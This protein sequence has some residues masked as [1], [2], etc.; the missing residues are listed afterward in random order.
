MAEK[1]KNDN[2]SKLIGLMA[3]FD[4][5]NS[6]VAACNEAREAG[7]KK[8]D[9]YSPFPVHGIDPAIGIKRT[10]LPLIVLGAAISAVFIGLGLQIYTNSM[11]QAWPFPGYAFKISGKPLLSIPANIPVTF[12]IIVLT[13]AITTFLGMWILNKLPR[14]SNPLHRI[15]RF[16]RV[17]NDKFFLVLEAHDEK[18]NRAAS[19]TQL[20]KWGAV[21]IEEVRQDL[22]DNELPKWIPTAAMLGAICLLL[23]P[24]AIF[25]QWGQTNRHP[26]LHVVPDMDWQHKS[27]TQTV[28]A[29]LSNVR[30]GVDLMYDDLRSAR[31][32]VDGAVPFGSLDIDSE[33][34]Y[35]VKKDFA[36]TISTR[37]NVLTSLADE[38]KDGDAEK[39]DDKTGDKEAGDGEEA[40]AAAAEEEN[41]EQWVT[42]FPENV[43]VTEALVKRGQQRFDIYCSACHGYAGQG[44]GLVND[45]ALALAATGSATWTA[46]R[47]LHEPDVMGDAK[48]P[49]GRIYDT[50]TNGRGNMGPYK[51]QIPLEDRW[52]IV[53]YVRALQETGIP[54]PAAA[55]DEDVESEEAST[56]EAGTTDEDETKKAEAKKEEP[57]KEEAKKDKSEDDKSE[58]TETKEAE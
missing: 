16:K 28:A 14:F 31:R 29:N 51:A 54:V 39:A 15:S 37:A 20:T 26:R 22:T 25:S 41:M 48:N 10:I 40:D 42:K 30:D 44:N 3:Q 38:K 53:A 50:I 21:A 11:D 58:E 52:A 43:K 2:D 56:E 34:N 12:E 18:F 8:M 49:V 7:Y 33:L 5:P 35:G 57:K 24:A 9:A 55:A 17:T 45:R 19:E 36:Y 6:L 4:D 47:N 1:N 13:S 46:A 32:P 23:P 27:K